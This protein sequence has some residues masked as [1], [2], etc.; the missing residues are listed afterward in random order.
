MLETD[1]DRDELSL[2]LANS[3]LYLEETVLQHYHFSSLFE[4]DELLNQLQTK[5]S[6]DKIREISLT[7]TA[8][9]C[10]YPEYDATF[11]VVKGG[12][13]ERPSPGTGLCWRPTSIKV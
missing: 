12:T 11:K 9:H 6:P 3:T 8:K 1:R 7:P 10:Q 4:H 5:L 2:P 13:I